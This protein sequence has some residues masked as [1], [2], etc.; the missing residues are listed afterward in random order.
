MK[1][2][3]AANDQS[4]SDQA[5]QTPQSENSHKLTINTTVSAFARLV[6]LNTTRNQPINLACNINH[7]GIRY[8]TNFSHVEHSVC[9]NGFMRRTADVTPRIAVDIGTAPH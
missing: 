8:N 3:D 7:V 2:W 5:A 6:L 4:Q 9:L 1:H